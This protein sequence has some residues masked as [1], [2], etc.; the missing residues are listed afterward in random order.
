[1]AKER[2]IGVNGANTEASTNKMPVARGVPAVC[3]ALAILR[4]LSRRESPIGVV[5]LAREVGAIPSSCL[6]ILR[7]F[8]KEGLAAVDPISKKYTLGAGVLSLACA[9]SHRNP[10]VQVVR[11]R[12]EE[13]SRKHHCAFA[14]L[15]QSN[16]EHMAIVAVGDVSPGVSAHVTTGTLLP[17]LMSASGRCFAAFGQYCRADLKKEFERLRWDSRPDFEVWLGEISDARKSGH[18]IDAG[19]QIRGATVVAVPVFD[20][21]R[22]ILGCITDGSLPSTT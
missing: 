12:L 19:H 4:F 21:Q 13:L 11:S 6:H 1:M 17:L 18:A 20:G 2:T 9:F 14:A 5:A 22:A 10:F 15:E 16:A 8:V 3:K 7:T